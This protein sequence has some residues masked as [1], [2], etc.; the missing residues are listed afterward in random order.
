MNPKTKVRDV[1]LTP[2]DELE[3]KT[4]ISA[5]AKVDKELVDLGKVSKRAGAKS[6]KKLCLERKQALG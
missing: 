3:H 4:L 6:F 2:K 5:R 1:A